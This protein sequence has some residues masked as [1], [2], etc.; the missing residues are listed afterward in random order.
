MKK[1]TVY[2]SNLENIKDIAKCHM[3]AFPNSFSVKLGINYVK[4]MLSWYIVNKNTFLIHTS[5][6]NI[7]TGYIGAKIIIPNSLGSTSSMIQF[8]FIEV[9]LNLFKRPHLLLDKIIRQRFSL[10]IKNILIKIFVNKN[11]LE[12]KIKVNKE[13][14]LGLIII[15]V[16]PNF[17]LLGIGKKLIN[18]F[19]M[20]AKELGIKKLQLSVLTS[21]IN[22]IKFYKKNNWEIIKSDSKQ[23]NMIKKIEIL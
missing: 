17:R 12:K 15:G 1:I 5:E 20:K 21:N 4:K 19:E 22:A 3:E 8:T 7:C 18:C 23:T 16:N 6:D 9:F 10:I 14:S 11:K 13:T 2:N